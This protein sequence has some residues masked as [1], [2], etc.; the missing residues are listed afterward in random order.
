METGVIGIELVA[1][2]VGCLVIAFLLAAAEAAL[3]RIPASAAAEHAEQGR[4]GGKALVA[5]LADVAGYLSVTTFVRVVAE[6]S[7]A[8]LATVAMARLLSGVVQPVF[9]AIGVMVLASFVIVGVSPRTLGRQHAEAIGLF[10]A[11][12]VV[13]LRRFLGPLAQLLVL[14]GNAVTPGKGYRDGPFASEAELR[15]LVDLAGDTLVIEA[16]ERQMIHSVF[17]LGDTVTREVMVPRPDMI[18]IEH[19]KT[20][21]HAM[22][23]F[24]R[25]GFSRLPVLGEDA[26][27]PVGLLYFK[28]VA[29]RTHDDPHAARLPVQDVMRPVP[30]VPDSKPVDALLREMQADQSHMAIVV[31]EYGGTAGLVTIEDVIEEI[32]GEI[33]DEYDHETPGVEELPE[34]GLR[35]PASMHVD[36]FADLMNIEIEEDDV[37]TVGGLFSKVLGRVPILGATAEIEGIELRADRMAG[38]RHR[39]ASIVVTPG[40]N[41]Q[42]L[43]PASVANAEPTLNGA[44]E[45][46]ARDKSDD[47]A[48]DATPE[49]A[50]PDPRPGG[51]H[52]AEE[53]R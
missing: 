5:V 41:A 38:R 1:G 40:P 15:D 22:T 2:F 28:D 52:L 36:D 53:H 51:A 17:E 27:D 29:Q 34:G 23:L 19:D 25:T 6:S 35:V 39:L 47:S 44:V 8:V 12:I 48:G 31:D 45:P 24:L 30:F 50:D 7:A 13:W 32:V 46:S 43:D 21:R 20:L 49:Q 4:R 37:D 10:A 9:A 42:H 14:I 18:T 33:A 3:Q 26:D 11:P 16:E